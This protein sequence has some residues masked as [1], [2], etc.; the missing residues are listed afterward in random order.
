MKKLFSYILSGALAISILAGCGS[1]NSANASTG[2]G[3]Y[4]TGLGVVT[5]ISSSKDAAADAEGTA[6]ADTVVAAV[7]LS[8]DGKITKC[9]IDTAQTKIGVDGT[10]K[11]TSDKTVKP[12]TKA[13]LGDSYG[14][15]QASPIGKEWYE[16]A[17]AFAEWTVGKSLDEVKGLKV[18]KVDDDH[19]AV[20]DIPD[21]TSSVTVSVDSFI[22]AIEKAVNNAK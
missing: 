10:G 4:K 19:V 11:I 21:L 14:M 6:Q 16:Q 7:T 3:N 8:E 22:A 20:P 9:V 13:E 18:K 15:K 17:E 5:S 2:T 1:S 12:P